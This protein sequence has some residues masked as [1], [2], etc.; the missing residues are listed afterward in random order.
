[1]PEENSPFG[2]RGDEI[3]ELISQ[4]YPP[5]RPQPARFP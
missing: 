5:K 2:R 4:S 1:M 3:K